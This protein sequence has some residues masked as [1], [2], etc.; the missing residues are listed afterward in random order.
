VNDG[1]RIIRTRQNLAF[2]PHLYL[3][4]QKQ[5]SAPAWQTIHNLTRASAQGSTQRATP[6]TKQ[7]AAQEY[8]SSESDIDDPPTCTDIQ[9]VNN[10]ITKEEADKQ[11]SPKSDLD[12]DENSNE[13]TRISSRQKRPPA[14]FNT[15]HE[16]PIATRK[17]NLLKHYNSDNECSD[18]VKSELQS[19]CKEKIDIYWV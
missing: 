12:S 18:A 9:E 19:V 6:S 3:F 11:D 5:L 7:P 14:V 8:A 10:T 17:A 16:N 2:D 15:R 4:L 13:S 1:S